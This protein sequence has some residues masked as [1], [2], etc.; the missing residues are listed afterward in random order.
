M[1][2]SLLTQPDCDVIMASNYAE[3]S[4][5]SVLIKD[6][7]NIVMIDTT[8]FESNR[9]KRFNELAKDIFQSDRY[10]ELWITSALRFFNLEDIMINMKY[11]EMMHVEGDNLL[12]GRITSLLP[13]LRSGYQGLAGSLLRLFNE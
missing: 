11:R 6:I 13:I 1:E 10:G 2:Q 8:M 12:Y 3:C 5:I 9:T 4:Q 7:P